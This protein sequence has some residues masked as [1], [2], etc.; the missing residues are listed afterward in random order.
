MGILTCVVVALSE[1]VRNIAAA[2]LKSMGVEATLLASL[3]ELPATLE[4][5]PAC[6]VLPEVITSIEASPLGQKA[7][8]ELAEFYPFGSE[9]LYAFLRNRLT[10]EASDSPLFLGK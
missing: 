10:S 3:E 1:N 6:G 9:M 4:K 5:I 2:A 8:Q 7:M